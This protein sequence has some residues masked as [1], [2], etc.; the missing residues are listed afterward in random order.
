MQKKPRIPYLKPSE[1][2][3]IQRASYNDSMMHYPAFGE[4]GLNVLVNTA[5]M[6][7]YLGVLMNAYDEPVPG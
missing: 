3:E 1:M 5:A 7:K 4:K 6:F 2:N